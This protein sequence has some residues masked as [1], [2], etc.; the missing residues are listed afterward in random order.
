MEAAL[1]KFASD[2]RRLSAR[3][4]QPSRVELALVGVDG[5]MS[6]VESRNR[7]DPARCS[8][9]GAGLA[10]GFHHHLVEMDA[11]HVEGLLVAVA[12][13]VAEEEV[14]RAVPRVAERDF[15]ADLACV[16]Q[17]QTLL[18]HSE[19]AERALGA[20]Q[21]ALADTEAREL[22]AVD[23]EHIEAGAG[24]LHR[25]GAASRSRS[26]HEAIESMAWRH[27]RSLQSQRGVR[28]GR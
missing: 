25:G 9:L 10:R 28:A 2:R 21:E 4:D 11:R 26:Y 27:R 24:H 7:A 12:E 19:A 6:V 20:R 17:R 15:D 18:K 22:A 5:D 3:V 1:P 13:D 14:L 16:W 8:H 23:D